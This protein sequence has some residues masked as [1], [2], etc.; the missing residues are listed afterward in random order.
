MA[1]LHTSVSGA[2]RFFAFYL[3]NRTLCLEVL[4]GI[5]YTP[6]FHEPSSLEQVLAI[7]MNCIEVDADGKVTSDVR[8][9]KRAAQCLRQYFD[10]S[11]RV[12]PPFEDWEVEL[13]L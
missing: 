8:A 6:V 4:D 11:F 7:F 10:P 2:V 3:A 9:Q 12:D 13:H 5:D 1:R